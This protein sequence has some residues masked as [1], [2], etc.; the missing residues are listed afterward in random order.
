MN[1]RACLITLGVGDLARARAF[2][3]AWGFRAS[4]TSQ[5]DVVFFRG[6]GPVLALF[7]REKL[8][9]DAEV[10][11]RPTGFSA[12]TLAANQRSVEDVDRVFAAALAA[13]ARA[14]K[15]PRKVFWGGYSGYVAD[16]DGHLWEIAHNPF[17]PLDADGMPRLET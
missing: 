9:E 15:T 2:Y 16:P 1:L 10:D 17:L 11:D 3:E 7:P 12:V 6:P 8:A 14:V 5:G 4:Q 13:G